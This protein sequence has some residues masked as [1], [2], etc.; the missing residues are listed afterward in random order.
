MKTIWKIIGF[1][2]LFIVVAFSGEI[3]KMVGKTSVEKYY[4]GKHDTEI[5][6][7]L[8]KTSKEINSQLPMMVDDETRL[9]TTIVLDKQLYYKYT[10]VNVKPDD[11]T[12]D[13]LTKELE[14]VLIKNV[15][16][17]KDVQLQFKIGVAYNYIYHDNTG[18]QISM[19]KIDADKCQGF[20]IKEKST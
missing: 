17:N 4:K 12:D 1:L 18:G 3:G 20:T 13:F 16:A 15:C 9:D 7:T 14:P 2:V 6:T 8:K 10:L 11:I 5:N 19:I